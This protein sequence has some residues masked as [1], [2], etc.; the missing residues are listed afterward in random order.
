MADELKFRIRDG[1][2][3]DE[4]SWLYVWRRPDT[5]EIVYVGTTGLPP[6][7]RAWLHINDNDPSIGRIRAVQPDALSGDIVVHAFRVRPDLDRRDVKRALLRLLD[8][9]S[10]GETD[11]WRAAGAIRIRLD[12][13]AAQPPDG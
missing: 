1:V 11:A 7:V 13:A 12:E 5:G 2:L 4:G 8:G 9:E 10:R 6:V 3:A